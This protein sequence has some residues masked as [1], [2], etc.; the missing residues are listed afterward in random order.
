MVRT[1]GFTLLAFS[2]G[3]TAAVRGMARCN[4]LKS[5]SELE[6][7]ILNDVQQIVPT[8]PTTAVVV[9]L[10]GTYLSMY[11]PQGLEPVDPSVRTTPATT[12]S[13]DIR[14]AEVRYHLVR[15]P[16]GLFQPCRNRHPIPGIYVKSWQ[17]QV[18]SSVT[19]GIYTTNVAQLT[20]HPLPPDVLAEMG[21]LAPVPP[22]STASTAATTASTDPME[23]TTGAD[24]STGAAAS[25]GYL[26]F[27][28][29]LVDP[30]RREELRRALVLDL[31]NVR[32]KATYGS[33]FKL[34]PQMIV[35]RP[36][37]KLPEDVTKT[38]DPRW[39]Q[40]EVPQ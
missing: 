19:T 25:G 9:D 40:L 13:W 18:V 37:V 31:M 36:R 2:N 22:E 6:Q 17:F 26:F 8:D 21:L 15:G 32:M 23:A 35:L 5:A 3:N 16:G 20:P 11:G 28:Y 30:E 33:L 34:P 14:A 38:L 10:S 29:H 4:I 39:E 1:A 24:S 27:R 7:Y 12:S